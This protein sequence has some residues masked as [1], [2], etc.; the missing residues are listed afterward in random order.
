MQK[1]KMHI[2][3]L[4]TKQLLLASA[5]TISICFSFYFPNSG[6]RLA[7]SFR[8]F[9]TSVAYYF[10]QLF[11]L[12]FT[13]RPTVIDF[14]EW[15]LYTSRWELVTF[16]PYTWEEF[17]AMWESY[18]KVLVSKENLIAYGECI[19][20]VLFYVSRGS[21]FVLPAFLLV[22]VALNKLKNKYVTNRGKKSKPLIQGEK[23][24]FKYIYP[25]VASVKDFISYAK[26]QAAVCKALLVVWLLHFNVFSI[27]IE[28]IAFY[29]FFCATWEPL[30]IYDQ[31]LK[32]QIDLSPVIR[33]IPGIIWF[34]IGVWVYNYICRSMAFNRLYYYERCNRVFLRDRGI[35]N[36]VY[37]KMGRGKTQM[38]TSMALSAEIQQFDDAFEIMLEK[39][40]MFPNFPW[41]RLRDELKK[42]IDRREI[43]D[44]KSCRKLVRHWGTCFDR[45]TKDRT[46]AQW[47][48]RFKQSKKL[49]TD[50]TFGYDFDHYATT[51]NNELEIV[52]LFDAVED[53]ACAYLV[54]TV[55]TTLIFA[56]Y[57]I[58][59]D[60]IIQDI[61]NMP[62][63]DNDFFS[64]DP[65]YQEA[66]SRHSHIID[67]DMLRLGKKFVF[68]NPKARTVSF[69][70]HVITEIDKERKNTQ[71]LKETKMND[72]ECNQRNDLF[73]QCVMMIRHAVVISNRVFI[74]LIFDLQRPEAWGAAGRELGDVIN[75]E[76]KGELAPVLPAL[77]PYWIFYPIFKCIKSKWENFYSEY[78]YNRSDIT[79]AVHCIKN[80]IA[81]IN[82]HYDKINGL[83]GKQTLKL[84]LQDG[85][86]EGNVI[87][88]KW[89]ILTKKDRAK[90]YKTSCLEA[91]FDSYK[92]NIMHIDDF[93][94]Y[95]S[96]VGSQEENE[97]Q[98]SYFQMDIVNMKKLNIP[99]S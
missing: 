27:V 19:G 82:N 29:F 35:V 16:F 47:Q 92:P 7:E 31:L 23:F 43:V 67:M 68:D 32:L 21:V 95:A 75:I 76:D 96:Y 99:T 73:N 54:F 57:S 8:D 48:K 89:R 65:R 56:N 62:L 98:N 38:I 77:S 61:G 17:A 41:Q 9:G 70:V 26:E 3:K 58:R 91:V 34:S 53:Y 90:R 83:F 22:S 45:A 86:M 6:P 55:K 24:V 46:V 11:D 59:V 18:W 64:R 40:L 94:M 33:F 13:V 79:L 87:K 36:T 20:D 78:I 2:Q 37:G 97:L 30:R 14:P 85:K 52:K 49:K 12:N 1:L 81:K 10:Q 60:S 88:E 39:D 42:R 72:K 93:Q 50:Y 63:R 28:A 51:Y 5:I 74:T 44:F 69:G 80:V 84:E 25:A 4:D 15:E 66:Y 71:D